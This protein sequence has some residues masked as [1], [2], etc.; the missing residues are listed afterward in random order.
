MYTIN[1]LAN[2]VENH[3]ILVYALIFLG[4]IIEGEFILLCTGVLVHLGALNFYFALPFVFMAGFC[5]TFLGYSI[6]SLMQ[7]KWNHTKF[8]KYIEKRVSNIM[9]HF[10][11]KPFWSIFISKF[12]MIN[13]F[14]IVF[15]GYQKINFKKYLKAELL[16]TVIWAPGLILLGYFFSYTAISVSH[17]IWRF[18]MIVLVL[19]IAFVLFDKLVSRIYEI[20]EEFYHNHS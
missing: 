2:L 17:E 3:Q 5:K 7:D 6:G 12:I 10:K 1:F 13:H 15:A 14:V 8:F 4:I 19:I 11:Q 9:P 18:L 16:S 20:F